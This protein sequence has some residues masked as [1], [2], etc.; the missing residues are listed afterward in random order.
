MV[1]HE[2]LLRSIYITA[3]SPVEAAATESILYWNFRACLLVLFCRTLNFYL[4][5]S[6]SSLCTPARDRPESQTPKLSK[7]PGSKLCADSLSCFKLGGRC[8]DGGRILDKAH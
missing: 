6:G 4:A 5:G 2:L 8:A 1:L 7:A 3:F